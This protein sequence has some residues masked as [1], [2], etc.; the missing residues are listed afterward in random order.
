MKYH[1]TS[2]VKETFRYLFVG[3]VVLLSL[4]T[5]VATAEIAVE[6]IEVTQ[7]RGF[8]Y[9]LGDL[10]ERRLQLQ[11]RRP[12]EF[13]EDSLP[14]PGRLN[15]WIGFHS[16]SISESRNS[17]STIYD[18]I[19]RYQVANVETTITDAGV[20]SHQ[21]SIKN[22][23]ETLTFLVPPS[24]TIIAPFGTSVSAALAPEKLP[25]LVSADLGR[26]LPLVITLLL[27]IAGFWWFQW[28]K[29][30]RKD[31]AP[32]NHCYQEI[33]KYSGKEIPAQDYAKVLRDIHQAFNITA[34]RTVFPDNLP[35]F[36]R[37]HE[38]F[39]QAESAITHYFDYSNS[40]FFGDRA[41]RNENYSLENVIGLLKL[42][43]KAER[44]Q[45]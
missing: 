29:Y 24:R 30:L 1:A 35:D 27:S 11:L 32:F 12:Y 20:P 17:T 38:S 2:L 43:S 33:K 8:G 41:G 28:G 36:F 18:I 14:S 7:P 15:R 39:Q 26:V 22:D 42:C 40:Y 37:Q 23:E 31:A 3:L 6:R 21:L 25:G 16:Y 9:Q 44:A 34:G 4:F 10:F 45:N 5:Q 19:L 13:A